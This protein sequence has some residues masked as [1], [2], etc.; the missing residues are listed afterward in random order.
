MTRLHLNNTK[1]EGLLTSRSIL[2]IVLGM[3]MF[4]IF[5]PIMALK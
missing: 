4:V 3:F 2:I 5:L 1:N